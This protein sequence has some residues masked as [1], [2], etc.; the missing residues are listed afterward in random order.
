MKKG[1]PE[2]RYRMDLKTWNSKGVREGRNRLMA[3]ALNQSEWRRR[4]AAAM[5]GKDQERQA[6]S[7]HAEQQFRLG[8]VNYS[9]M[10]RGTDRL[11]MEERK[12]EWE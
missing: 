11:G 2:E 6:R 4:M 1:S 12:A 5:V 10:L 7:K 8:N 9:M 3:E